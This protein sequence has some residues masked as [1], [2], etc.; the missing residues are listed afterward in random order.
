MFNT[1]SI[2]RPRLGKSIIAAGAVSLV[3][4]FGMLGAGAG[5]ANA[6]G[7]TTAQC[8]GSAI[9]GGG[10]SFPNS[11]HTNAYIAL[12]WPEKCGS[13]APSVTYRSSGSGCGM[14]LMGRNNSSCSTFSPYQGTSLATNT[15]GANS[16]A[17][18]ERFGQSDDPLSSSNISQ[19]NAGTTAPG[20]EGK[21][22]QIPNALGAIAVV[23]N[24]PDGCTIFQKPGSTDIMSTDADTTNRGFTAAQQAQISNFGSGNAGT[25]RL[26]LTRSQIEG[27]YR[28]SA[29]YRTWGDI[30]PWINDGNGTA[31]QAND[32]RCVNFP[33]IRVKRADDSGSTYAFKDF[34]NAIN[35]SGSWKS[36]Y[37]SGNQKWPNA[38]DLVTFDYNN[39]S[40]TTD[41]VANCAAQ[42]SNTGTDYDAD[43]TLWNTTNGTTYLT[44][45]IGCV[46][47]NVPTLQTSAAGT[48]GGG[49]ALIDK[50]NDFDG[51]IGYGV[52][53]DARARKTQAFERQASGL[54]VTSVGTND[55]KYWVRLQTKKSGG[56]S[57]DGT[58]GSTFADPSI[59]NGYQ[60]GGARGSNCSAAVVKKGSSDLVLADLYAD[61]TSVTAVDSSDTGYPDCTLSFALV[62]EDY[63][64]P[65]ALNIGAAGDPA[66]AKIAEEKKARTVVD[67]LRAAVNEGQGYVAG[68][69]YA[70]LPSNIKTLANAAIDKVTFDGYADTSAPLAPEVTGAPNGS[71][72]L[73]SATLTVTPAEAGGTVEYKVNDGAYQ[74]LPIVSG[75]GTISLTS[76]TVGPY[77]VSVRQTDASGNVGA[78]KTVTWSVGLVSPP[79]LSGAPSGSTRSTTATI[80]ISGSLGQTFKC[81]VDGASYTTCTSPLSLTGLEV[82]LHTV[83]VKAVDGSDNESGATTVSWTVTK[84]AAPTVTVNPTG[85]V[86]NGQASIITFSGESGSTYT[87]SIDGGA[88][89][90]CTSGLSV[91]NTVLGNHSVAVKQTNGGQTSDAATRSWVVVP[92]NRITV[93]S[94][95]WSKSSKSVTVKVRVPSG[96]GAI[97]ANARWT[98]NGVSTLFAS[99][100]NVTVAKTATTA[101]ITFPA[102]AAMK[103]A[104]N[105]AGTTGIPVSVQL[106]FTP[107]S[108]GGVTA[109]AGTAT[110]T[111]AAKK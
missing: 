33:I 100:K 57:P 82:G 56:T 84:P 31:S 53:A 68:Y 54:S 13:S 61:T 49:G 30:V 47:A 35:G 51:S 74:A 69:D 83:S 37:G 18:T 25:A 8:N 12:G 79:Q 91:A 19:I 26:Q 20:D 7:F 86:A 52:L 9:I 29:G 45:G 65:Y 41:S 81:S 6:A 62:W 16:R 64:S 1:A 58:G 55:D 34:L 89:G 78:V 67:Y 44:T 106:S 17:Q 70:P 85:N 23:V 111:V 21:I 71:T 104:V 97:V 80:T 66:A 77:V 48:P 28:R 3:A 102:S 43:R 42:G 75:T 14:Q 50:V 22:I 72:S 73:T 95:T 107:P 24:T 98:K 110:T 10:A 103:T 46:E 76:L 63:F 87:C 38:A 5:S 105:G 59:G 93:T 101:T 11:A 4:A 109:V 94:I 96:G 92:D 36:T 2:T 32:T 88:Y 90:S 99:P 60:S 39:D 15:D 40:D 27:I 108:A